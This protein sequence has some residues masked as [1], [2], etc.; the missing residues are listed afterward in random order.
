M[1]SP[2]FEKQNKTKHF[3]QIP[4]NHLSLASE[5]RVVPPKWL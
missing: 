1:V 4:S 3:L 5:L 2:D